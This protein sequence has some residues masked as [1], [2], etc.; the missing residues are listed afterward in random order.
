MK[1][2]KSTVEG[3]WTEVTNIALTQ[4]QK[5]ILLSPD[6]EE[7][8]EAK[9]A[10]MAEIEEAR[11]LVVPKAKQ[12]ALTALYNKEKAKIQNSDSETYILGICNVYEFNGPEEGSIITNGEIRGVIDG[13]FV[14]HKIV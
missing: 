5:D 3:K 7:N 8:K 14:S 2:Y 10:L 1:N 13:M 12:T 9:V 4:E 11:N 6:T